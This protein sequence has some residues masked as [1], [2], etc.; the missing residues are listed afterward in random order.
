MTRFM[1][2][3]TKARRSL[4]APLLTG[5]IGLTVA[6][7]CGSSSSDAASGGL[8][9]GAATLDQV[10]RGRAVV[11]S[12]GC[13]D[14]HNRGVDNP[15]D[16]KWLAGFIGP[17]TASGPGAFQI[18]PFKTFCPNITPDTTTGIGK[19]TERQIFN[20]LRYGLDP[21]DTSDVV[22]TSTTPGQGGFPAAPHYLAP[23]MPW[24]AVRNMPDADLWAIV[25]YLKHGVKA[26]S[27]ASPD[28]Q[29]PPDHWA[30]SYTPDKIGP[31]PLPA[32]PAGSEQFKP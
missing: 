15:S 7:G 16:P 25:A 8:P 30:S 23:P 24:P 27:N 32:Y 26:V 1:G 2:A 3:F 19:F 11:T 31:Y 18:G 4:L 28:S 20:A 17:A 10:G 21:E 22:I 9:G 6:A 12:N 5:A 14:C 13:T 29:G